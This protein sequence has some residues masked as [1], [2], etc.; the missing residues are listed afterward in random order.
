M[1]YA[2]WLLGDLS[3]IRTPL[4]TLGPDGAMTFNTQ[5]LFKWGCSATN[6]IFD[7][8]LSKSWTMMEQPGVREVSASQKPGIFNTT[9]IWYC[10]LYKVQK[11]IW[12]QFLHQIKVAVKPDLILFQGFFEEIEDLKFALQQSALLNKEYEKVL[13][14]MCQRFGIP[15]P[16]PEHIL[17]RWEKHVN[18]LYKAYKIWRQIWTMEEEKMDVFQ[19]LFGWMFC[20]PQQNN[21]L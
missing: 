20:S 14:Q 16:N 15:Y 17:S 2:C 11:C 5:Y 7:L 1:T 3:F 13:R 21:W 4:L 6:S 8:S 10:P 12:T 18:D 9:V 19:E